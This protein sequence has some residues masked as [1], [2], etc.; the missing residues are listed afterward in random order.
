GAAPDLK[1]QVLI[2]GQVAVLGLVALVASLVLPWLRLALALGGVAVVAG[3]LAVAL[4]PLVSD[5]YPTTFQRPSTPYHASSIAEG[6]AIFAEHCAVCHG[7]RGGGDGPAA[8]SLNRRPPDLRA[9][10]VALH[11]AGDIF[12]WITHGKPPM[13]ASGAT[14]RPPARRKPGRDGRAASAPDR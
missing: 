3:G 11:T 4:P 6:R 9:H 2:G 8:G 12:W 13:P 1:S 14:L 5:A 10:H 7:A